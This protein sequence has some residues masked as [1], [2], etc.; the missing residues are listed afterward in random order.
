MEGEGLRFFP[1]TL[2]DFSFSFLRRHASPLVNHLSPC[3]LV[4]LGLVPTLPYNSINNITHWA[5]GLSY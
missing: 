5:Q 3:V 2:L 4:R 1:V